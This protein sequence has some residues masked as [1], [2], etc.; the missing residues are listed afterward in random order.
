MHVDEHN[1][2]SCLKAGK[3]EAMDYVV[4]RYGGLL[5]TVIRR[6]L[7]LIPDAADDC[8]NE[9][10]I[11]IWLHA[12]DYDETRG[13]FAS[14]ITAIAKYQALN[15]LRGYQRRLKEK[16]FDESIINTAQKE[17]FT[18]KIDDE[19][20]E[21]LS[22]MLSCLSPKD[23]QLFLRVYLEEEPISDISTATG[24]SRDTI[25]QRLSR[26]KKKIRNRLE[27]RDV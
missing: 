9:V 5:M 24:M 23:Q 1:Y 13:S 27:R 10:L 17:D 22:A 4:D 2:I 18:R 20:S 3:D 6:R 19:L 7:Y 11:K 14:W 12:S 21:Q 8:L 15:V 26:G 16:T 25:Y